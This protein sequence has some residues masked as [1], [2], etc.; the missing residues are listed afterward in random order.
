MNHGER[1]TRAIRDLAKASSKGKTRPDW[2]MMVPEL[3]T[4]Q[5]VSTKGPLNNTKNDMGQRLTPL[6]SRLLPGLLWRGK[7]RGWWSQH[8]PGLKWFKGADDFGEKLGMH[9]TIDDIAMP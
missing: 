6:L 8:D 3:T 2:A 1:P 4:F 9:A 7:V 5:G